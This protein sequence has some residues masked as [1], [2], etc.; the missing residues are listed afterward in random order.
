MQWVQYGLLHPEGAN[1]GRRYTTTWREKDARE[2]SILAALRTAGFSLQR[3]RQAIDY[4]RDL[5]H[6]PMSTGEFIVIRRSGGEPADVIKI[7]D[8][9]EAIPL[10]RDRGQLVM[11]LWRPDQNSEMFP[12]K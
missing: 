12:S 11:P 10:L 6:N 1:R 7:T 3:L 2:A 4:L 5:G 9:G 8:S